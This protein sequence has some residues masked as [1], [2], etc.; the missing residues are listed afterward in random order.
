MSKDRTR[1]VNALNALMRGNDL[2]LD[3][4]EKPNP[5]QISEQDEITVQQI[6]LLPR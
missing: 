1:S 2:G 4:C 3:A 5:L 6:V